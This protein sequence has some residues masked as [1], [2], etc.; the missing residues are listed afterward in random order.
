MKTKRI[1]DAPS[2]PYPEAAE[3]IPEG[4]KTAKIGHDSRRLVYQCPE[5]C[6]QSHFAAWRN[7]WTRSNLEIPEPFPFNHCVFSR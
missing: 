7:R 3:N 2:F 1:L 6:W 4:I 5:A